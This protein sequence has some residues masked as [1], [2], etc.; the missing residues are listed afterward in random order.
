VVS[1]SN[2][3]THHFRPSSRAGHQRNVGLLHCPQLA[4]ASCT[5]MLRQPIQCS[6]SADLAARALHTRTKHTPSVL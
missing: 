1:C 4:L 6:C 2:A 5:H 3:M